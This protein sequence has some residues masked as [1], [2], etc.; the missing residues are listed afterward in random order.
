MTT[1]EMQVQGAPSPTKPQ[2]E[3]TN[4]DD[5]DFSVLPDELRSRESTREPLPRPQPRL[6]LIKCG[7]NFR[8]G[9]TEEERKFMDAVSMI[10]LLGCD[11]PTSRSL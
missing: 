5:F 2:S 11:V 8:W 9:E 7:H 1:L 6:I 4:W 10:F 3:L